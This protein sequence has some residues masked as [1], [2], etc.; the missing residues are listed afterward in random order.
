MGLSCISVNRN[1]KKLLTFHEVTFRA[2]KIKN[3]SLKIFFI[4]PE[5]FPNTQKTKL[6]IVLLKEVMNKFCQ[7]HFW[8]SFHLF[9]RLG[10]TILLVHKN[11]ES[12]FLYWIFF[13]L[14]DIFIIYKF[15]IAFYYIANFCPN[16][17]IFIKK[18]SFF[19]IKYI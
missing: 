5:E 13:Q 15:T 19:I 4:F 17:H 6:N 11:I 8:I 12:Y 14:L 3:L 7:K 2:W 16:Y 9:Y 10:Q 1:F 18:F